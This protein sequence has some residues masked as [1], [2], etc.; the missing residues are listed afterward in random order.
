I[1][2]ASAS[3]VDKRLLAA[4]LAHMR[5]IPRR[6]LATRPVAVAEHGAGTIRRNVLV[7]LWQSHGV[8]GPV[9]AGVIVAV[10]ERTALGVRTGQDVVLVGRRPHTWNLVTFDIEGGGALDVVA[11]ALLVAMQIGD[12][13]GDQLALDVVPGAGADAIA[14]IDTRLGATLFLAEIRVPSP[15]GRLAAQ[16]LSL[17][18]ASLC[19]PSEPAKVARGRGVVGNEEARE[20]RVH[21]WLL[22]LSL[23]QHGPRS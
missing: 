7:L 6:V 10:G 3:R 21:L 18:S 14:R 2:P 4:P 22:L 12:V 19:V 13:A 20:L 15:C 1:E 17:V 16:R 11:V 8:R 23:R 5:R 9:V